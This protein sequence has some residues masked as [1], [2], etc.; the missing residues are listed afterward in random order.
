M[1]R[2]TAKRRL[3]EV[4][5]RVRLEEGRDYVVVA[6]ASVADVPFAELISWVE[7]AVGEGRETPHE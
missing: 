2:N 1:R 7:E 3:R 5:K 4:L 6:A